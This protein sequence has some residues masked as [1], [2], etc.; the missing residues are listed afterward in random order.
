MNF[1]ENKAARDAVWSEKA[2]VA[3]YMRLKKEIVIALRIRFRKADTAWIWESTEREAEFQYRYSA[4]TP[5]EAMDFSSLSIP[6]GARTESTAKR[7]VR[8]YKKW[9]EKQVEVGP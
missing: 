4:H 8:A 2:F 9:R 6:M 5:S 3:E 7:R 1:E